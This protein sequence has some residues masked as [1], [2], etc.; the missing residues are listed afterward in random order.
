MKNHQKVSLF[1]TVENMITMKMAT[2]IQPILKMATKMAT[3]MTTKMATRW[4]LD[5]N[6]IAT[7]F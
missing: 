3:K 2:K 4:Q 6:Q 7:H 5:G 1:T